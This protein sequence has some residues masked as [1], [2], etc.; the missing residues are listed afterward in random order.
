M[1]DYKTWFMP[2][3]EKH[4]GLITPTQAAL[5]VG[6]KGGSASVMPQFK[7]MNIKIH[8]FNDNK[9]TPLIG[10]DDF[11]RWKANRQYR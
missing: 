8:C 1:I 6:L 9:K 7:K 11:L 2:L 10:Y 4:H 5:L 3:W